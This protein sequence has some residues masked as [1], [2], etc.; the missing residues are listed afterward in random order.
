M[1]GAKPRSP[2]RR[3]LIDICFEAGVNFFDTAD[4]YSDG[5]SEEILGKALEGKRDRRAYL[6]Q[7]LL[8]PS[9]MGPTIPAP[10]AIIC[11]ARSKLACAA[12]VPTTSTST[13]S[14]ASTPSRP[15]KKCRRR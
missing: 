15:S 6:H 5:R 3:R 2:K 8:S 7:G 1:R 14:T 10:R 13:T 11:A 4:G 9:A 12:S